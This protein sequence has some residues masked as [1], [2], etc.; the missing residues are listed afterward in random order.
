M[1][2]LELTLSGEFL[3]EEVG[4]LVVQLQEVVIE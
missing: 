4:F 1:C 2:L 3:A